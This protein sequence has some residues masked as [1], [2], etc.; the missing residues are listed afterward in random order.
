MSRYNGRLAGEKAVS[1]YKFFIVTEATGI[2]GFCVA[3]HQVYCG[4]SRGS[5]AGVTIQLIVS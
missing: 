4:R 1:R 2:T 5:V 3:I